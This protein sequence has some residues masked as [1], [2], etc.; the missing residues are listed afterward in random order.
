MGYLVYAAWTIQAAVGVSLLVSWARHA[1]GHDAGLV[2]THILM[3]VAFLVPWTAFVA[4]GQVVWAWLG[5]AIL[6]VFIGFGDAHMMRRAQALTPDS[7]SG[8]RGYM[9]A[10]GV[11]LRGRLGRRVTFH[12]LFAPVIFFGALAVSIIATVSA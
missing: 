10:V 6:L 11:A 3:M 2:L 8:V 7:S 1:R 5:F 9:S 12:A 4:T